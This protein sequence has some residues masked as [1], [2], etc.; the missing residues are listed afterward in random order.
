MAET[1]SLLKII[2]NEQDWSP[3]ELETLNYVKRAQK[4]VKAFGQRTPLVV[5][6]A[7]LHLFVADYRNRQ[8]DHEFL[9]VWDEFRQ[10][11]AMVKEHFGLDNPGENIRKIESLAGCKINQLTPSKSRAV[12]SKLSESN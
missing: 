5:L 9:I 3:I 7:A 2:E 8:M 11:E 12:M 6:K 1:Q 4:L 10:L